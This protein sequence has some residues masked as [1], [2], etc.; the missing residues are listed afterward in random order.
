[1][2]VYYNHKQNKI[3]RIRPFL[4]PQSATTLLPTM[5]LC[6]A[7]S[8]IRIQ[9]STGTNGILFVFFPHC[10]LYF[11]FLGVFIP[12][13]IDYSKTLGLYDSAQVERIEMSG[14]NGSGNPETIH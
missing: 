13:G 8:I 5:I 4:P 7:I 6:D 11:S 1:V 2:E 12:H 10:G 3:E 14:R 9:C